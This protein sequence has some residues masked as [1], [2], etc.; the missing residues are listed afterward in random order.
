MPIAQPTLIEWVDR[1]IGILTA[2][3]GPPAAHRPPHGP[4]RLT[5]HTLR[6][7]RCPKC[8]EMFV[9]K[10]C[11]VEFAGLLTGL[12]RRRRPRHGTQS[13]TIWSAGERCSTVTPVSANVRVT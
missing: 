13:R 2:A 6:P 12:L 7:L 9:R 11:E 4:L 3:A 1:A 10:V 8:H 5:S